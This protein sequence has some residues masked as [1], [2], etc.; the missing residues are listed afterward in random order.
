ME[1]VPAIYSQK[2]F[3]DFKVY[4]DFLTE[5]GYISK[6]FMLNSKYFDSPQIRKRAFLFSELGSSNFIV[7]E[8]KELSKK[9]IKDV[10]NKKYNNADYIFTL[11]RGY[12]EN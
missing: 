4:I 10:I 11:P 3:G 7:P 2:F 12:V 5:I 8:E 1:N 9:R 6:D